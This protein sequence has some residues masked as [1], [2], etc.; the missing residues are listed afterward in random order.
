MNVVHVPETTID[1]LKKMMT[2]IPKGEIVVDALP[3]T[4]TTVDEEEIVIDALPQTATVIRASKSKRPSSSHLITL[5]K[6][7]L[8]FPQRMAKRMKDTKVKTFLDRMSHVHINIPLL[9]DVRD[10]SRLCKIS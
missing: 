10:M 3:Q 6:P 7:K 4:A 5:A 8:P 2:T 1:V 9:E